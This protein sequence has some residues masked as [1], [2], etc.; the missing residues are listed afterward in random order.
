[1]AG[2]TMSTT[3][4]LGIAITANGLSVDLPRLT[5]SVSATLTWHRENGD[6]SVN[7]H[8][9]ESDVAG[10]ISIFPDLLN[11]GDASGQVPIVVTDSSPFTTFGPFSVETPQAAPPLTATSTTPALPALSSSTSNS[12]EPQSPHQ[13]TPT[14]TNPSEASITANT[15]S[16]SQKTSD[17]KFSS[18]S[19]AF[20]SSG[21]ESTISRKYKT[22]N[23]SI[24]RNLH[25][26]KYKTP[27]IFRARNNPSLRPRQWTSNVP[28]AI[29]HPDVPTST[30][31]QERDHPVDR[32]NRRSDFRSISPFILT[33]SSTTGSHVK[34][35]NVNLSEVGSDG[36][37][38]ASSGSSD[39]T[40][41]EHGW[42]AIVGRGTGFGIHR[43][44]NRNN[45]K[46]ADTLPPP[47]ST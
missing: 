44:A 35:R 43:N 1:M 12:I 18:S 15:S 11:P 26:N 5:P 20:K 30:S 41:Q 39:P 22:I 34:G 8:F 38:S 42:R 21:E 23:I 7:W 13:A 2:K 6:P 25:Q 29:G 27:S 28:H 19:E 24:D 32:D 17:W 33:E 47:Y 9:K 36:N 45:S 37:E 40:R 31:S 46:A 14:G 4:F 10:G 3:I 16:S